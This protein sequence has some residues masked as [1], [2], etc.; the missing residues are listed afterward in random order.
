VYKYKSI[1]KMDDT[2]DSILYS[3]KNKKVLTFGN[4]GISSSSDEESSEDENEE[5]INQDEEKVKDI[6]ESS[7]E[8]DLQP[9]AKKQFFS[10]LDDSNDCITPPPQ[11]ARV[12]SRPNPAKAIFNRLKQQQKLDLSTTSC[13]SI[14]L[15]DEDE[16]ITVKIRLHGEIKK[17]DIKKNKKFADLQQLIADEE[18]SKVEAVALYLKQCAVQ[19]EDTLEK[20]T[21]ADIIECFIHDT[22]SVK[23]SNKD[24]I[25]IKI[26]TSSF[27]KLRIEYNIN[28]NHK[29]KQIFEDYADKNNINVDKI[30]FTFDGDVIT[31]N[32]TPSALD[33]EDGDIIDA[34]F[35]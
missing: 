7:Q 28:E 24:T 10:D 14:N 32:D 22:S 30:K 4:G 3:Y 18:D 8:D 29:L 23:N 16:V 21:V 20:I 33:I 1:A 15:L 17:F 12:R 19:V 27:K 13:D 35:K 6:L 31:P 5:D 11:I 25:L 2:D 26:Q 34:T 9:P